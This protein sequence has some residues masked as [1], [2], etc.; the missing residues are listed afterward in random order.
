VSLCVAMC[1]SVCVSVSLCVSLSVQTPVKVNLGPTLDI[2]GETSPE[3]T[4][5]NDLFNAFLPLNSTCTGI[6]G[7][8]CTVDCSAILPTLTFIANNGSPPYT[9]DFATAPA[10]CSFGGENGPAFG[11]PVAEGADD[12]KFVITAP[13][14]TVGLTA[15]AYE[16]RTGTGA[17]QIHGG[18]KSACVGEPTGCSG[19]QCCEELT[20]GTFI[21]RDCNDNFITG[22]EQS[23]LPRGPVAYIETQDAKSLAC[24]A[25]QGWIVTPPV[26]GIFQALRDRLAPTDTPDIRSAATIAAGGCCPCEMS[27]NGLIVTVTDAL[28]T[29]V[30][31]EVRVDFL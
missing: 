26:G 18:D 13:D 9:W 15:A 17:C 31:I 20:N 25:D 19:F 6:V 24:A 28:D 7:T 12:R 1:V 16:N 23:G 22:S 5:P 29:Q 30:S 4:E 27:F 14:R 2:E 11:P 21:E 10:G 8:T 3:L